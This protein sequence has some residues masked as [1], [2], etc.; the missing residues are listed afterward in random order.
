VPSEAPSERDEHVP[1]PRPRDVR[2]AAL[3]VLGG[4]L[5]VRD[6]GPLVRADIGASLPAYPTSAETHTSLA[7]V[8]PAALIQAPNAGGETAPP[9][10]VRAIDDAVAASLADNKLPGCVVTIVG[11]GCADSAFQVLSVPSRLSV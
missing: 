2:L 4:S 10:L 6:P 5:V 11:T 8:L 7:P 3:L 9:A 1:A